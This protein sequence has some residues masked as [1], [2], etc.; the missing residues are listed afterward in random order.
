RHRPV[1]R[2]GASVQVP[3]DLQSVAPFSA[4]WPRCL[5]GVAESTRSVL[6]CEKTVGRISLP[7]PYPCRGMINPTPWVGIMSKPAACKG[8]QDPRLL[9]LRCVTDCLRSC[10][11]ASAAG[12]TSRRAHY[13]RGTTVLAPSDHPRRRHGRSEASEER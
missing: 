11:V 3:W 10:C 5:V 7:F 9:C 1:R 8:S 2:A 6:T 4:A 12:R 13:R